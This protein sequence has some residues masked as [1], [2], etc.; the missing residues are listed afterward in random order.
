MKDITRE[1]YYQM[2][3]LERIEYSIAITRDAELVIDVEDMVE[4][5]KLI[6]AQHEIIAPLNHHSEFAGDSAIVS[7][8]E[9]YN[10][11]SDKVLP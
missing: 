7:A 6:R 10:E 11:I 8:I 3:L 5:V 1:E 4:L 9:M 2:K